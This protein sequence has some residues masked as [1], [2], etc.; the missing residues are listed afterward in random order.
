MNINSILNIIMFLS[1]A[2]GV[3]FFG[4]YFILRKKNIKF[5]T[6]SEDKRKYKLMMILKKKIPWNTLEVAT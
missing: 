3:V 2:F 4:G 6:K 5:K 1:I